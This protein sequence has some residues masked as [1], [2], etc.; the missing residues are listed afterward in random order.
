MKGTDVS[1]G[2]A[3]L[4]LLPASRQSVKLIT[5]PKTKH[6]VELHLHVYLFMLRRFVE[7][8][9]NLTYII[10]GHTAAWPAGTTYG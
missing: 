6:C 3:E 7:Q 4:C 9:D 1:E 2:Q 10:L 8:R 5:I